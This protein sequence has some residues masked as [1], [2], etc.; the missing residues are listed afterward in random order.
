MHGLIFATKEYDWQDQPGF[1]IFSLIE[2]LKAY[3]LK[4]KTKKTVIKQNMEGFLLLLRQCGT[5]YTI[6]AERQN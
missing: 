4:N 1:H 5:L 3:A 6:P 2:A